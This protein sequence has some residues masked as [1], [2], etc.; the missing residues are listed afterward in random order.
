[1]KVTTFRWIQRI[2]NMFVG[3]LFL[4]I[5][6]TTSLYMVVSNASSK[7]QVTK[8]VDTVKQAPKPIAKKVFF[9]NRE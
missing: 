8:A 9:I 3:I 1:M 6:F 4:S 2:R 5:P 7:S